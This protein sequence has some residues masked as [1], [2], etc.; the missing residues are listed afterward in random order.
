MLNESRELEADRQ[1]LLRLL[2]HY[3]QWDLTTT[4]LEEFVRFFE[5][6]G[7]FSAEELA[8]ARAQL[9]PSA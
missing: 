5:E 4:E 6:S 2:P 9:S 8:A 7:R 1:A 3:A